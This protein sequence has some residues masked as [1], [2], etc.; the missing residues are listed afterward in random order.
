MFKKNKEKKSKKRKLTKDVAIKLSDAIKNKKIK[1]IIDFDKSECNSIKSIAIK[2]NRTIKETSRFVKG[3]M[4]M[5]SKV[6]IRS[7]VYDLIDVFWFP[8]ETVK[9]IYCQ[10][11][12]IKC[13]LYLCLNYSDSCSIFFN[14]ICKK[15]CDIRESKSRNLIFEILKQSKI[16]KRFDLSYEFWDQ[17]KIRDVK[18]KKNYG[19]VRNWKHW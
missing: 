1:T 6:S 11:S 17:F 16:I 10:N 4:L 7:F 5:F 8:D 18:L 12:I 13:H 3:K 2:G 19:F 9:E 15:E 14:F